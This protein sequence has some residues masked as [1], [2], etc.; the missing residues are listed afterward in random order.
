M[1][2]EATHLAP[3]GF[4]PILAD[5]DAIV[6]YIA[7]WSSEDICRELTWEHFRDAAAKLKWFSLCEIRPGNADMNLRSPSRDRRYTGMDPLTRPPIVVLDA[8]I[9]DGHHRYRAAAKNQEMG[10]WG[11][12]VEYSA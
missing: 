6:D 4:E 12:D 10:L 9:Q 7:A 3:E 11:Y 5:A 1:A 8:E 2:S